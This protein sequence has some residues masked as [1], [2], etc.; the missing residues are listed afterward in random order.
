MRRSWRRT[1]TIERLYSASWRSRSSLP[2][3]A[4]VSAGALPRRR[5]RPGRFSATS[6]LTRSSFALVTTYGA[7]SSLLTARSHG[8]CRLASGALLGRCAGLKLAMGRS[9]TDAS[10]GS[11]GAWPSL[12]GCWPAERRGAQ[13]GHARLTYPGLRSARRHY[14]AEVALGD[15]TFF[16]LVGPKGPWV[17][18]DTPDEILDRP[19]RLQPWPRAPDHPLWPTG[20]SPTQPPGPLCR[21]ADPRRCMGLT[22]LD[23]SDCGGGNFN[24][25]QKAPPGGHHVNGNVS[26]S[27][28][29][30]DDA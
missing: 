24:A 20:R 19:R 21:A 8:S 12:R 27:N 26:R 13:R 16:V 3:W 29:A 28:R 18:A 7:T 6:K 30:E 1:V 23:T 17:G 11:V 5:V 14:S 22:G 15:D 9:P 25:N 4:R 2:G 10:A